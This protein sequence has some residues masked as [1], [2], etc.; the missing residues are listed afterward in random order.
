[1]NVNE[2]RGSVLM[3]LGPT[4]AIITKAW[5]LHSSGLTGLDRRKTILQDCGIG[6]AKRVRDARISDSASS[7]RLSRQVSRKSPLTSILQS[8]PAL[9]DACKGFAVFLAWSTWKF[10]IAL[11]SPSPTFSTRLSWTILSR[12]R[13]SVCRGRGRCGVV[14]DQAGC[15]VWFVASRSSIQL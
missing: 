9:L 6:C 10:P 2:D 8:V 14:E 5:R 3:Y 1:M 12:A 15:V 7:L 11:D 13:W 4:V